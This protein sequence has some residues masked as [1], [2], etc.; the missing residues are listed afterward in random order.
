MTS[1]VMESLIMLMR[2]DSMGSD[3]RFARQRRPLQ[4]SE[5]EIDSQVPLLHYW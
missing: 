2:V 3:V 4:G 1:F 5:V